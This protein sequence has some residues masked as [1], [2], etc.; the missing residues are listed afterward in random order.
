MFTTV[1]DAKTGIKNELQEKRWDG[2]DLGKETN[3]IT[4]VE[5]WWPTGKTETQSRVWFDYL[6][7]WARTSWIQAGR[8]NTLFLL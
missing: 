4:F 8:I 6:N 1:R 2:E 7:V 5:I 3:I